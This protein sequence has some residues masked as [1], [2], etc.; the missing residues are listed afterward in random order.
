MQGSRSF[1]PFGTLGHHNRGAAEFSR[2]LRSHKAVDVGLP[3]AR[4]LLNADSAQDARA[5]GIVRP[6]LGIGSSLREGRAARSVTPCR[7]LGARRSV[8]RLRARPTAQCSS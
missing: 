2:S 7:L 8:G 4:T 6:L 1:N 5:R 3:P